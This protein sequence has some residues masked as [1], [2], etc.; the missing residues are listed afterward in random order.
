VLQPNTMQ[1]E[2]AVTVSHQRWCT[3]ETADNQQTN[4]HLSSH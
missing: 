4:T 3:S 1:Y 2:I